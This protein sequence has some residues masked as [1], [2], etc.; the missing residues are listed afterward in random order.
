MI[1][2]I[3]E[4][5]AERQRSIEGDGVGVGLFEVFSF[6]KG[7]REACELWTAVAPTWVCCTN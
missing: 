5:R 2:N 4:C 7:W 3:R 1:W 6:K